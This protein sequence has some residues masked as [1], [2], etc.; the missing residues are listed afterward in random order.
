MK[1][2]RTIFGRGLVN[3][4]NYIKLGKY[5]ANRDKLLGGK[6]QVRSENNIY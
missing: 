3:N 2:R 6:L 4:D 1:K 5:K